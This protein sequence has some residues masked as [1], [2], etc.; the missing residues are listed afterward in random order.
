LTA[1]ID[2]QTWMN[3]PLLWGERVRGRSL[4]WT[5]DAHWFIND[6]LGPVPHTHEDATEIAY[7][8]QGSM[9]IQIGSSKRIYRAGDLIIMP[10]DMFHNYWFHGE[11]TVCLFVLVAPNH[12][13]KRFRHESI[14]SVAYEGDAPYANVFETD[15]LPS[16]H[17]F[18]CE[19]V[20]LEPG[21]AEASRMLDLQDRVIYVLSGAGRIQVG[22]LSGALAANQYQYIPAT[23]AHQ[24]SNPGFEPLTYLSFIITDPF[25]QHGTELVKE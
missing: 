13:Y 3:Q 23:Y 9:E 12:K 16:N 6:P 7:L 18:H 22:N 14:P 4:A 17:H 21:A 5:P 2:H 20:T 11:D 25:T 8:T 24:I 15:V 19:R 10:P 1:K